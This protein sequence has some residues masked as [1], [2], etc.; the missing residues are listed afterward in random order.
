MG[1]FSRVLGILRGRDGVRAAKL[2]ATGVSNA[3]EGRLEDA[4]RLYRRATRADHTYALA[5]LN[6]GLALQDLYNRVC[7]QLDDEQRQQRLEEIAVSLDEARLL[8]ESLA[9]AYSAHGYVMQALGRD[10]DTVAD[11]ERFLE[12]A[13]EDDKLRD[14]V[15]RDLAQA[16]ER[17]EQQ[18]RRERAVRLVRDDSTGDE[19]LA[20]ACTDLEHAISLADRDAELWWA[21]GVGCRRTGNT[22]RAV[23]A[24]VFVTELDPEGADAHRELSSIAFKARQLDLALQH[25]RRAYEIDPTNAGV[26][27]NLGV[28]HMELGDLEHA[29]EFIEL[30]HELDAEDPIIEDCLRELERAVARVPS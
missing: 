6:V 1:L 28:C 20:E 13:A 22:A 24:F 10:V 3:R 25:A 16:Q 17:V 21:L 27:C 4:L 5:H 8:D 7:A 14:G 23:E 30:A 9:P 29:R 15:Q 11:F 18:Q 2:V 12:L 26:V 19:E